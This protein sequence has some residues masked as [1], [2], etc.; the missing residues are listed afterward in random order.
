MRDDSDGPLYGSARACAHDVDEQTAPTRARVVGGRRR[1]SGWQF[2]KFEV[3]P[4]RID[5]LGYT[6]GASRVS[7]ATCGLFVC[8]GA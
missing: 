1:V 3:G 8:M 6:P 5:A 4:A 7:F 2:A